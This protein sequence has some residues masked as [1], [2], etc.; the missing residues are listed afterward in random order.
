ME[1]ENIIMTKYPCKLRSVKYAGL[2]EVSLY[3]TDESAACIKAEEPVA[4]FM[5]DFQ[6]EINSFN[7]SSIPDTTD[8]KSGNRVAAFGTADYGLGFHRRI[9]DIN[10][11]DIERFLVSLKVYTDS[12]FDNTILI[13]SIEDKNKEIYYYR[14]AKFKYFVNKSEWSH[15]YLNHYLPPIMDQDDLIKIFIWN[16]SRHNIILDDFHISFY[17]SDN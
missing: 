13:F 10:N 2:S 6:N 16:E 12:L 1:I 4:E 14:G 15:V 9:R 11:G 17:N 3:S 5:F 8:A 7:L